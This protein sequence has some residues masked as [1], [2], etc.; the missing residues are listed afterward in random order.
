M[1]KVEKGIRSPEI[2]VTDGCDLP[3]GCFESNPGPINEQPIIY[4][5]KKTFFFLINQTETK[6]PHCLFL[7]SVSLPKSKGNLPLLIKKDKLNLQ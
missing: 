3:H 5:Y 1:T 2:G 7:L 6:T 4:H